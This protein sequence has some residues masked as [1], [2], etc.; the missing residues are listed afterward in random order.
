MKFRLKV[1]TTD[2]GLITCTFPQIA[3]VSLMIV[4]IRYMKVHKQFHYT[5]ISILGGRTQRSQTEKHWLEQVGKN[6][7]LPWARS[8][9]RFEKAGNERR[10]A[11]KSCS[12][13]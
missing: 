7:C 5:Q 3:V 11:S 1:W 10:K 2:M 9:K 8:I 6:I 13:C 4:I 12:A